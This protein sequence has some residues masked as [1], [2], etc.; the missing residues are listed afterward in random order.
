MSASQLEP[1]IE[2][3]KES[4]NIMDVLDAALS[5]TP[6]GCGMSR[7]RRGHPTGVHPVSSF[8]VVLT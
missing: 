4:D 6:S 1:S 3:S 7:H 5:L 2:E 8:E